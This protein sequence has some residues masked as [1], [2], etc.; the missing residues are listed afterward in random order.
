MDSEVP[1]DFR[2]KQ[3]NGGRLESYRDDGVEGGG[4][5]LGAGDGALL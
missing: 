4:G 1:D 3:E 5:L 2:V